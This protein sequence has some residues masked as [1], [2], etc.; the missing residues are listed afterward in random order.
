M[1]TGRRAV[2]ARREVVRVAPHFNVAYLAFER[3]HEVILLT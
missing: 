1:V 3:W 2:G